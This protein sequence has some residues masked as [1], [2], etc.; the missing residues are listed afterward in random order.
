M[1]YHKQTTTFHHE[2]YNVWH[3]SFLEM[4]LITR[5]KLQ[6]HNYNIVSLLQ[7]VSEELF[8]FLFPCFN[9]L[10]SPGASSNIIHKNEIEN[11]KTHFESSLKKIMCP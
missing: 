3:L 11:K 8:L 5:Q 4:L 7:L 1:L 9:Q 10:P 2:R 6:H